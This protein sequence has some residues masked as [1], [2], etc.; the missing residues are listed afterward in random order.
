LAAASALGASFPDGLQA[1]SMR[2]H[3]AAATVRVR[4]RDNFIK[5]NSMDWQGL[6]SE[7][8]NQNQTR[9]QTHPKQRGH[10]PDMQTTHTDPIGRAQARRSPAA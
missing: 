5:E 7:L 1:A 2:A 8:K 4:V 3:D 9:I 10:L 6:N